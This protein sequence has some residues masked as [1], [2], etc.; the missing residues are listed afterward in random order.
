MGG[1]KEK[2]TGEGSSSSDLWDTD[3]EVVEEKPQKV[4]A[5]EKNSSPAVAAVTE[6]IETKSE[7]SPEMT[8]KE[9]EVV[10][11]V[12]GVWKKNAAINDLKSR[13]D[14]KTKKTPK[15]K[16]AAQPIH[17]LT[18]IGNIKNKF[19][20]N[21]D[22]KFVAAKVQEDTQKAVHSVGNLESKFEKKPKPESKPSGGR[23]GSKA[24]PKSAVFNESTLISLMENVF[25]QV[26]QDQEQQ[27]QQQQQLQQQQQHLQPL[28]P[29]QQL[30]QH[31]HQQ[32][33]QEKQQQEKQQKEKLQ[34]EKQQQEKQQQEKQQEEK[35][36]Q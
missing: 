25:T 23:K 33:Q 7:N 5:N 16:T 15:E 28:K 13:Y 2:Q 4:M 9:Q 30:L 20:V 11:K 1:E 17:T 24:R 35:L 29:P 8:S 18:D 31:H 32:Q 6:K 34:Q 21:K 14:S 19:D 3:T 10:E 36:Q 26:A 22:N 12:I 27:Q